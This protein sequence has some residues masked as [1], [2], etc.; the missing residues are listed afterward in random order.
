MP[1]VGELKVFPGIK[2]DPDKLAMINL[3]GQVGQPFRERATKMGQVV[4]R[5]KAKNNGISFLKRRN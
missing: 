3:E 5:R 4:K 1:T 2:R